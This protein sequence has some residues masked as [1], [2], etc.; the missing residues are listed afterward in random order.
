MNV[1][2]IEIEIPEGDIEKQILEVLN[3]RVQQ[4]LAGSRYLWA[5]EQKIQQTAIDLLNDMDLRELVK[6]KIQ[7]SI[8][9]FLEDSV[10]HQVRN[11]VRL[12]VQ[13]EI[14]AQRAEL[15]PIP[16]ETQA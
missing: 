11:L 2:K 14:A 7:E 6:P 1:R 10:R 3:R 8:D 9:H 12:A 4:A 5:A 15:I 16:E 13:R